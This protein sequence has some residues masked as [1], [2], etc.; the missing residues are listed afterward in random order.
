MRSIMLLVCV[1]FLSQTPLLASYKILISSHISQQQATQAKK[2]IA[3]SLYKNNYYQMHQ[4][5]EGYKLYTYPL[6]KYFVVTIEPI[7]N[8]KV[9][10]TLLH[11]IQQYH[12]NAFASN[13][14]KQYE[15]SA[16]DK[17]PQEPLPSQP[18]KKDMNTTPT[19]INKTI[20]L[21]DIPTND[22]SKYRKVKPDALKKEDIS[23]TYFYLYAT[24]T[25][26]VFITMLLSIWL[27][28]L[29]KR[30]KVQ[31]KVSP[32]EVNYEVFQSK[33]PHLIVDIHSH[34][35]PAIDDGVKSMEESITLVKKF[36]KLGYKKI[37]TTPHIMSHR[38]SNSSQTLRSGLALLQEQIA[39]ENLDIQVEIASEYYLDDHLMHLIA[40][41]DILT[42]GNNYLLFEMSYINH[43]VNLEAMIEVMI[44]AGYTPVLAHPERYVYMSKNFSKYLKLKELGVLFQLN[45]NS[46]AGYY[47]EEVKQLAH[48]LIE[49][50]I[51]DFIGSDVHH[52]RHMQSMEKVIQTQEFRNIFQKNTILNNTL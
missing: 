25:L 15:I 11:I 19:I 38:Y 41:F 46:I 30:L 20:P 36:H 12:K 47:S 17:I 44:E 35:I 52:M 18:H 16:R 2:K 28:R 23:I 6:G 3:R 13:S 26:L 39:R 31:Y 9:L 33:E 27:F 32:T 10:N 40:Q 43:P 7:Q 24:I 42:F 50:G 49:A 21:R 4:R 1:I 51:I 45:I 22:I 34:L 37:I 29:K 5:Y 8:K 14:T 48:R